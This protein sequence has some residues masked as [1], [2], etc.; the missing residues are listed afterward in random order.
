ML[1]ERRIR[2]EQSMYQVAAIGMIQLR[3][4]PS[5]QKRCI[6]API[7]RQ[8]TIAAAAGQVGGTVPR[9]AWAYAMER[10]RLVQIRAVSVPIFD[11]RKREVVAA[12]E[13][14]RGGVEADP[15]TSFQFDVASR[16]ELGKPNAGI[17]GGRTVAAED[18]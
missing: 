5:E 15:R 8:L 7:E 2:A 6:D 17:D 13:R 4:L 10:S 1:V 12:A 3:F 16:R 9:E 18:A 14:H 11:T